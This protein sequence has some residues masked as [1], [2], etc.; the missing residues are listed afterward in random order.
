MNEK[1]GVNKTVKS[2]AK[3][4]KGKPKVPAS[5][6]DNEMLQK[7]YHRRSV[8][9]FTSQEIP[10][11]VF[12]AILE[13]GRLAPCGVNLQ[14]WTFVV[15]DKELWRETFGSTLPFRGEQAVIV[16]S[17]C[18]RYRQVIQD[19][20]YSPLTEYTIAVVNASL[21]AMNMNMAAEALG[22]SS[23]MLSD[24]G[25]SGLLDARYLQEKLNLPEGTV[26]LM[27]IVFGY[28]RGMYPVMPPK[29]PM[30]EVAV[31]GQYQSTDPAAAQSW[32]EQMIAGYNFSHRGT[33]FQD[34]LD[35]Y[36]AKIGRA[37]NDLREMVFY[38][39]NHKGE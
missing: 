17:D 34:Q 2:L 39:E 28:A 4:L 13:A 31:C 5:L 37:E 33:T 6:S 16:I 24:T 10:E 18:H 11:E 20:P 25:R 27:T 21:A 9:S 22:V 1:V 23:V 3:I 7:I 14:S 32:L 19:F 35:A 30:E 36:A 26:P 38:R 15:F 29:L 12:S 8:R